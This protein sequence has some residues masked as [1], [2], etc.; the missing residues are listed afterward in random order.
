MDEMIELRC[1]CR[2][3]NRKHPL[4]GKV[5]GTDYRVEIKCQLCKKVTVF[6]YPHPLGVPPKRTIND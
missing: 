2:N 4:L 1:T 3:R 5:S 6:A